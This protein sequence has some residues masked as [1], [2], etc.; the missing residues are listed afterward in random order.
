MR[1]NSA[2]MIKLMILLAINLP[3]RDERSRSFSTNMASSFRDSTG[4]FASATD[5]VL[6]LFTANKL[7]TAANSMLPMILTVKASKRH[8]I[9]GSETSCMEGTGGDSAHLQ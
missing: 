9:D 2:Y 6:S 4:L 7:L 3:S 8:Q 5:E 1:N